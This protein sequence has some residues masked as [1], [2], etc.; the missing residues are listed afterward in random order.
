MRGDDAAGPT[1]LDRLRSTG[2]ACMQLVESMGD[3]AQILDAWNGAER[4]VIVDAVISNRAPGTVHRID[5]RRGVPGAWRSP[6]SHLIGLAEAIELGRSLGTLPDEVTVFGIEASNVDAGAEVSPAVASA[7][8]AVAEQI[9]ALV[10]G[11][12]A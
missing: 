3:V 6:S 9:E 7:I 5:G 2:P 11:P 12:D 4:V 1:V 10:S 8:D